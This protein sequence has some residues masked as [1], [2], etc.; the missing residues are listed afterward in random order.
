MRTPSRIKVSCK[1]CGLLTKVERVERS[2]VLP[3]CSECGGT[4]V[5][6]DAP[7][8]AELTP[9]PEP[10]PDVTF[11]SACDASNSTTA[12]FC[13]NCG[14][15]LREETATASMLN[16][17]KLLAE[18]GDTVG[19]ER[20][21]GK[22]KR[23]AEGEIS[24]RTRGPM[25]EA[26]GRSTRKLAIYGAATVVAVVL[27]VALVVMFGSK[28]DGGR[29]GGSSLVHAAE[30]RQQLE[31]SYEPVLSRFLAA[32]KASDK[33]AIAAMASPGARESVIRRLD[34]SLKRYELS[35]AKL[36]GIEN[37]R[38]LW[39]D[40]SEGVKTY[41][42]VPATARG[43]RRAKLKLHWVLSEGEWVLIEARLRGT[44]RDN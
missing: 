15:P 2:D 13:E 28:G 40:R 20:F 7:L 25:R 14:E 31:N 16:V 4:Q 41:F 24:S 33:P 39:L 8:R 42:S 19:A 11:C 5:P 34:Q 38:D 9:P 3:P 37:R 43:T 30:K 12:R 22:R 1:S 17:K 6:M 18:H 21:T 44:K 27:V 10:L 26:A 35:T 32:W 36:P 29:G 23:A